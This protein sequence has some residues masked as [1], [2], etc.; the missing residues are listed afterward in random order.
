M[1]TLSPTLSEKSNY[2]TVK[3]AANY[4]GISLGTTYN[5]LNAGLPHVRIETNKKIKPLIRIPKQEFLKW[6][7]AREK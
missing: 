6:L 7:K 1:Q 3:D 2:L 5:L 4:L